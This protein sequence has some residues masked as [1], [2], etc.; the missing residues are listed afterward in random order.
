MNQKELKD[1]LD[2]KV[3]TYNNPDFIEGDPICI[4]HRFD[5]KQD[6]E[7]SGFLAAV[8]AWGQRKTIISKSE[9]FLNLMDNDPYSFILNHTEDDLKRF[10]NFRH[11]TFNPTDALYF[12]RFFHWFYSNYESMEEAFFIGMSGAEKSIENG[13]K[14][15]FNLFFSLPDYPLRT[16]KHVP[17]PTRK[18]ACKRINSP[19]LERV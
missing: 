10:L 9:E 14:G 13:L 8:F 17:T 2:L 15:F 3:I 6:I 11:R 1:F 4:P 5:K 12:I 7:I 18:S 16:K 19:T